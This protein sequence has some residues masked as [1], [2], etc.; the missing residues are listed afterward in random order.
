MG[1]VGRLASLPL[2]LTHMIVEC[3]AQVQR[4]VDPVAYRCSYRFEALQAVELLVE[5]C[6][7]LFQTSRP[8]NKLRKEPELF[9]KG[10]VKTGGE[11]PFHILIAQASS[12][13]LILASV[14]PKD[15]RESSLRSTPYRHECC[16]RRISALRGWDYPVSVDRMPQAMTSARVKGML[17]R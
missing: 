6:L 7:C 11:Q 12:Q 3:H 13:C 17:R 15:P 2:N 9:A 5:G 10:A 4:D 14:Q 8:S 1:S 16:A